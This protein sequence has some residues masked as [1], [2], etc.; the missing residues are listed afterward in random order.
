[1]ILTR[2]TQVQ[3]E[4]GGRCS[5]CNERSPERRPVSRLPLESFCLQ[6]VCCRF[7]GEMGG[8]TN[9]IGVRSALHHA[10]RKRGYNPVQLDPWY[11][12]SDAEYRKVSTKW[13]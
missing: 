6:K 5:Q 11:F 4:S 12:P 1:M 10:L 2:D 3:A 13:A 9:C 8:F 7:V